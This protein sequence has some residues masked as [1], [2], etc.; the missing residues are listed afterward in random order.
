MV[1]G[2]DE[3]GVEFVGDAEVGV[4]FVVLEHGVV[5]GLVA[6][7]EAVFQQQG[8]DFGGY[9]RDAYVADGADEHFY[10][11][12]FIVVVGEVGCDAAL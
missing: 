2:V 7:D 4:G 6:F 9:D 10:L 12:A 1:A 5:A 11:G 3:S 8:V